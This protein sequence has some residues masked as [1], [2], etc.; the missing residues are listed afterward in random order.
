MLTGKTVTLSEAE[1]TFRKE[2]DAALAAQSLVKFEHALLF[3]LQ[4][5]VTI[6]FVQA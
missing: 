3:S 6:C 2:E 5:D 1:S 4:H